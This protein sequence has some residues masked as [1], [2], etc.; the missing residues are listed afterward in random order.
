MIGKN[1]L[2]L[3]PAEMKRAI[4][5]YIEGLYGEVTIECIEAEKTNGSIPQCF[6]IT[7]IGVT[8]AEVHTDS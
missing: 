8:D 7:L 2:I 1:T 5:P 4:Q 3:C 6:E